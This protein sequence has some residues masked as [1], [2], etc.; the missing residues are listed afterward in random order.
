MP[1]V[2]SHSEIEAV[3]PGTLYRRERRAGDAA[4][5][6][7]GARAE[8]QHRARGADRRALA[9]A[10]PAGH[11]AGGGAA[12]RCLAR[13]VEAV[14]AE[15]A[16]LARRRDRRRGAGEGRG[17]PGIDYC[18]TCVEQER[19]A[20]AQPRRAHH[21]RP[22]PEGHRRPRSPRVIAELGGDILDISQTLVGDYFTMIIVVDIG[23]LGGRPSPTSRPRIEAAVEQLGIQAHAHARGRRHLAAPGLSD[24]LRHPRRLARSC[25]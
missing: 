3:G 9:V 6:R 19:G 10:H 11:Q 17:R 5:R 20:G 13:G 23:A 22:Q 18:A 15:I 25:A 7:A 24:D 4:C 8:R 21:H 16:G 14:V 12:R 2:V 1:R